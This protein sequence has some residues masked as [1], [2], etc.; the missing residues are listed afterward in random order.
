MDPANALKAALLGLVE[1]LTEFVPVSSTGHILL[2]E[3]LLGFEGPKGK[4][5]EVVIQ[6]GAILAVIWLYRAKILATAVGFVRREPVATRFAMAV[7]AA[8]LPAAA[9]G[10]ALHGF[11]KSALFNPWV[12]SVALVAGG[13]LI[14]LIERIAPRPRI[15]I[16][17]E[18]RLG[19][20]LKIGL[21][22][23]LAMIPGVSRSGATIMGARLFGVDRAAA[24]E[25]SFFLAM[26][27]MLGATVYD[28][29]KNR[30]SFTAEGSLLIAIGFVVAFLAA[31]LVVSS[32]VRFVS[33]YGFAPFAW[34]RIALGTGALAL[35]SLQRFG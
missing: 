13:F 14:L 15:K 30:A 35:L 9:V 19:T 20:A 3:E 27:T 25:F 18:V 12:V 7:L 21:C 5:F 17:E 34:Y 24:A 23:C 16:V 4:V 33:R 32:L 22:Q 10:V 2:L 26:P 28:S 8:F 11:I 1:G 6:F 31:L 29:W